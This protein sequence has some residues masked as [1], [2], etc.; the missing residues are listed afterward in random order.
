MPISKVVQIFFSKKMVEE[1]YTVHSI[2]ICKGSRCIA[3]FSL[4]F[5]IKGRRVLNITT[6]HFTPR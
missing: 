2:T 1:H 6:Y 5:G 4:S 3:P